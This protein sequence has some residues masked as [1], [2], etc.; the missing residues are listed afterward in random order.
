MKYGLIKNT[1]TRND[2]ITAQLSEKIP[3]LALKQGSMKNTETRNDGITVQL[4]KKIPTL[5]C[6]KLL[7]NSSI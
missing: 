4:C 1:E 7:I 2:S 5:A 6:H 3:T